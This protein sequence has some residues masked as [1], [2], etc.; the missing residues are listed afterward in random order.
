LPN[1][2]GNTISDIDADGIADIITSQDRNM[3]W[4]LIIVE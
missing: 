2:N 3:H 4:Q 1:F